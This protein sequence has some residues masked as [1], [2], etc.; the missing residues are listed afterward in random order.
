[1]TLFSNSCPATMDLVPI[2]GLPMLILM[3]LIG[4]GESKSQSRY[5]GQR[6]EAVNKL[7]GFFWLQLSN[8]KY[9]VENEP[10][11]PHSGVDLDDSQWQQVY[12]PFRWEKQTYWFRTTMTIPE[13]IVGRS[14]RNSSFVLSVVS[15]LRAEVY[16]DGNLAGKIQYG[17]GTV[18]LPEELRP[19]T[20]HLVALRV[21]AGK[22]SGGQLEEVLLEAE[23]LREL[24][25]PVRSYLDRIFVA[26]ELINGSPDPPEVDKWQG[27]LDKAVAEL[28]TTAIQQ[29]DAKKVLA[30]VERSNQALQPLSELAKSLTIYL[31]GQSHIDLAWLWRWPETVEVCRKTFSDA[32]EM[33]EKYPEYHYSQSMAQA[34]VW[35]EEYYPDLFKKIQ[36]RV[37]EGR[38]E[39]VGGMWVEPDCNIPSGESFA[40]Q[41]LYGKRYFQEKFGVDVKVG[42]NID[43][44]G[45]NWNLPQFYKKAGVE[46]FVTM[47]LFMMDTEPFPYHAFLWQAP[48]GSRVKVHWP[49]RN[50]YGGHREDFIK[51]VRSAVALS[52]ES[53]LKKLLFPYGVGDHGGGPT[54]KEIEGISRLANEPVFFTM[55]PSSAEH[56]FNQLGTASLPLWDNE[57]YNQF[58][59]GT[60]T[61]HA[62]NKANNRRA[63]YLMTQTETFSSF[64]SL[65]G[66]IYPHK[67]LT[68]VWKKVLFNQQHDILPGT[69]IPEVHQD[70]AEDYRQ[71]FQ[72]GRKILNES[73]HHLAAQVNTEGYGIPLIVFNPLAWIRTDVAEVEIEL[74]P[75]TRSIKV[76]DDEGKEMVSQIAHEKWKVKLLFIAEEVPPMG[77]KIFSIKASDKVEKSLPSIAVNNDGLENE[78]FKIELDP[79]TGTVRS[80][81]DKRSGREVLDASGK[82]NLLQAFAD[83]ES[84]WDLLGPYDQ[85]EHWD[86]TEV[87]DIAVI[88]QGPVRAVLQVA[89]R[90][91]SSRFVQDIILYRGIPRIDCRMTVDWH[92]KRTLLK[93]VFPVSVKA[94]SATYEIPYAAISRSTGNTTPYEQSQYEVPALQWADLSDGNYGVSL[95]NDSKYGYDIKGTRMRL[96]LLRGPSSPDPHADEGEHHFT[97]SLYPHAGDWRAANTVQRGYELNAPLLV[98]ISK[99]HKG[100]LPTRKSFLEVS[101]SNVVAAVVKRAEDSE[102]W[103]VRLYES[104][105]EKVQGSLKVTGKI[106]RATETDLLERET[107]VISGDGT[108]V[109]FDMT[110]YEIKTLKLEF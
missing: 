46:S 35:M 27:I 60:Y 52:K 87:D 58:H 93:A 9:R 94:D 59:R 17:I 89:R 90:W 31:P 84:A 80:I 30:S 106:R 51:M 86:L 14:T 20:T 1:M 63:E 81:K 56:Y 47:K 76:L 49:I 44:F 54:A 103:I 11:V 34:Y 97:Y 8:W 64:A 77:Y 33:M 3:L 28:D 25:A 42:W 53:G 71:I 66:L 74:P 92:E 36:Q 108:E 24:T 48:D 98:V 110:P 26:Q 65:Y 57:L 67:E 88:E 18:P 4:S 102:A 95:L 38:W 99:P 101:P 29:G 16:F 19:G 100:I 68:E 78:F 43:S 21:S 6:W 37:K 61:S 73:L 5:A 40:R 13:H 41:L 72:R 39:I 83:S 70:A 105:G 69:S 104:T 91:R 12:L 55:V 82:G 96:T 32:L 22:W 45:Y 15:N 85:V 50:F 2:A 109:R 75:S 23:A 7:Q 107:K 62:D 10:D 79:A